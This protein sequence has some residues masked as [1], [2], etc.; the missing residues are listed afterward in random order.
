[1]KMKIIIL[2]SEGFIG[3]HL[4]RYFKSIGYDVSGC[5]LYETPSSPYTY[6]KISRSSPE[7]DD[8]FLSKKY[9]ACINASG[10][11]NVNYSM[12][13]PVGDFEANTLDVIKVLDAMR[14]HNPACKYLHISSAAVYGNPASLP[15]REDAACKPLSAYGWHKLLSEQLCME[16]H[17]LYHLPVVI[18][19]PFS[20]YGPGLKKQLFW[21]T[22]QKYMADQSSIELWGTGSESR[23][24]IYIDDVLHCFEL[25]LEKA[26]MKG[27]V[28][29]IASG[30]QTFI[31]DVVQQLFKFVPHTPRIIFNNKTREGDPL[32]WQADISKIKGLGFTS[33]FSLESGVRN[34][35]EWL[36]SVK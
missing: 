31:K 24:F 22:Y 27:E 21:D 15:V 19:R 30:N 18:V 35:S 1:M 25:I 4:I 14:K 9:D 10:S 2:G 26:E 20:I 13:N 12:T 17:L 36:M 8:I 34:L 32:N 23:D 6:F 11:G 33:Q 3:K 29:N 16:Y 28:Y 5:D 7:F